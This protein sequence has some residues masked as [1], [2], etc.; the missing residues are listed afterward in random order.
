MYRTLLIALLLALTAT[1]SAQKTFMVEKTGTGRRYFY[2][3]GDYMKLRVGTP[4]T[5]LKG[6]LWAIRDTSIWVAELRPFEIHLGDVHAVYKQFHFPRKFA[7]Y[8]AAAGGAF[9]C[10]LSI[11]HLVNNEP[12][13]TKD[14]LIIT[15][16]LCGAAL[17]SF[18][19]SER[20]CKTGLKWRVKI[21]DADIN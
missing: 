11:N 14:Q 4:D 13:V 12:V 19:L 16:S 5:L 8:M 21:L 10:I 18:S 15:G 6:K 3:A 7:A 17:I 2:H 1:V 20:K 9:F